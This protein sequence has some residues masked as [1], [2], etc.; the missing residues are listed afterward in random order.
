VRAHRESVAELF[1]HRFP[2]TR[3]REAIE[4]VADPAGGAVKVLISLG[5]GER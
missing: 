1:S 3:A 4:C 2:L 5:G